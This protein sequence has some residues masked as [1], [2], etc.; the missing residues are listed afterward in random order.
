MLL[1]DP[2]HLRQRSERAFHREHAVRHYECVA[3]VL[4]RLQR[5]A[6]VGHVAVL[7]ALLLRL[8]QPHAVDDGGMVPLVRDDGILLLGHGLEESLIGVPAGAV[9]DRVLGAEEAGDA[10][11]EWAMNGLG[12][13]DET[14]RSEAI[15]VVALGLLRRLDDDRMIGQAEV[16]VGS[17]HDDFALPFDLDDR[18]L[19][20]LQEQL[21][22]QR[23]GGRHLI[24]L[25]GKG[26]DEGHVW[27]LRRRCLRRG[28]YFPKTR[29]Q[30][31]ETRKTRKRAGLPILVSGFWFLVSG[32]DYSLSYLRSRRKHRC[33]ATSKTTQESIGRE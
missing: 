26:G 1:A 4:R 15:A 2:H 33:P 29:N 21:T 11:L 20:R 17:Q 9:E 14:H 24:E 32:F 30:K 8:R 25:R 31:L 28:Y 7:V 12:P 5:A 16:V 10:V 27:L 19:G 22:L 18:A 23:A 6:Q 3:R 13:A